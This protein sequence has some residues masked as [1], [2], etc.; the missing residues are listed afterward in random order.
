MDEKT[1]GGSEESKETG[2]KQAKRKLR[3]LRGSKFMREKLHGKIFLVPSSVT[4]VGIF[5]GFLA[6]VS[7]IRGEFEYAAKCIV[8]AIILDGIDGRVARRLKATSEFGKEFDSLSDLIAFGVAPAVT[9][10]CWAFRATADE[11]GVVVGF[12]YVVC[13]AARL[14][15][16]NVDAGEGEPKTYFVGL[17]SPGGAAATA[18]M[19]YA[20]PM[21]IENPF[22]VGALMVY[23][24]VVGG[25][26][27]STIPFFSVKKLK[28]TRDKQKYYLIA[29]AIFVPLAWKYS[30]AMFM[31]IATGYAVSGLFQYWAR[32]GKRLKPA[33]VIR[34]TV[35]V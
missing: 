26:M 6:I 29:L 13:A 32:K 1:E 31:L 8:L 30:R 17:P 27:V 35:I 21:V 23:M 3:L 28:F 7:A 11:F 9:F 14:A 16:F 10:Y 24:A 22:A 2:H 33:A 5:C 12:V 20:F 18:S 34:T 4:V 15:R 25:L 19:V